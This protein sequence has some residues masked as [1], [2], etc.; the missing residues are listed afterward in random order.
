[1]K[2]MKTKAVLTLKIFLSLWAV[3]NMIVVA[4][5]PN[6]LSFLGRRYGAAL[7]PYANIV[8]LNASWN[9]FSPDPAHTM[10]FKYQVDFLNAEGENTQDSLFAYFPAE[11]NE[12]VMDVN[13][14]RELYVMRFMAL[15]SN[16][17]QGL[18]AP[19]LCRQHPGASRISVEQVVETIPPLEEVLTLPKQSV[20]ELSRELNYAKFDFACDTPE[21]EF[22]L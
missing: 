7:L 5:V 20:V 10:Y 13:R 9:F 17:M 3:Y 12:G 15:G 4:I 16:R 18:F 22:P 8:G 1:M 6:A 14:R 21:G 2:L 19:W 11:K